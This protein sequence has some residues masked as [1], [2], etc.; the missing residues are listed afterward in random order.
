MA[1]ASKKQQT[2]VQL[3]VLMYHYIRTVTDPRDKLG[4]NLSVTPKDFEQQMR[5]LAENKFTTVTP[6]DLVKAWQGQG[7]LPQKSVL[8]T[9]D[10]GYQD[11]YDQ[12]F[13]VLKKYNLKAT[14]FVV[15]GFVGDKQHRYVTWD[16]IAEMDRSGLVT[17]A[18]HTLTHASLPKSKNAKGEIA[19]SKKIMEDFVGHPVGTFAYPY[20]AFNDSTAALVQKA[21]YDM[22]FTTQGGATMSY[23]KRFVLPRVRISGGLSLV[24][25][26]TKVQPAGVK[27]GVKSGK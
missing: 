23:Q 25:Y 16:E 14:L 15:T 26:K 6:D 1:V 7:S 27:T 2:I 8:L 9:F 17:M 4:Y 20:G 10:D 19:D 13:P 22:A 12:A 5:Y 24:S 18:S 3:P 21:G 11:F